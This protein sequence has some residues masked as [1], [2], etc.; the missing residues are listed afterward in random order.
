M[1]ARELW[2]NNDQLS[3]ATFEVA[4][5]NGDLAGALLAL[6]G[7]STRG[8][9]E[10]RLQL[11]Q[12]GAQVVS[13]P[14]DPVS[15]LT[16]VLVEGEGFHGDTDDYYNPRNSDL[17]AVLDR[18][19]GLPILLS[20]VW[21][22]VGEQADIPVEGVGLPGHFIVRVGD[23]LVDPFSAGRMLSVSECAEMVRTLTD[24]KMTWEDGFLHATPQDQIL[25]RVL[26][27]LMHSFQRSG[28][29]ELLFRT[30][31]FYGSLRPRDVEPRL[32]HAR[33]AEFLGAREMAVGLFEEIRDHFP[34]TAAAEVA[35]AK[36]LELRAERFDSN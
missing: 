18:R 5:R 36:V 29:P 9:S 35:G 21:M 24:G 4:V 31:A 1:K 22:L 16:R 12:L 7:A 15:A 20:C 28:E 8:T 13:L 27:N 3:L 25:E 32:L 30:A 11:L 17:S 14:M 23:V 10:A 6:E 26:R 34:N 19:R 33:L 2:S